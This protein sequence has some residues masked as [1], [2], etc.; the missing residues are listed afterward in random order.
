M[1]SLFAR[2]GVECVYPLGTDAG[3]IAAP[4]GLTLTHDPADSDYWY[5]GPD[6][7]A[8]ARSGMRRTQA[9]RFADENDPVWQ[10]WSPALGGE[11]LTVLDGWSRDV[12]RA[13]Q[14]TDVA[15]CREAI[16]LADE[17]SL[18]G[19]L[20][21]TGGGEPVAFLLASRAGDAR[22]VHFAKG[23]RAHSHAYPW[24]FARYAASSG[25]A[26]LNFEQDLGNLGL[27]QSKRAYAPARLQPKYRLG[28]APLR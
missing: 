10:S 8:L 23:R 18:E 21:R 9:R 4:L 15:E 19:G 3:E 1:P 2:A 6:M 25:A 28:L 7:A 5:A 26:W 12:A 16:A 14:G 20:V 17:L 13:P 22:V 24:M 27:A 11:A